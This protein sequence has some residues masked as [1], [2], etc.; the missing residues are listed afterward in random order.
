[1]YRGS[2]NASLLM[3]LG[4]RLLNLKQRLLFRGF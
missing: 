4:L 3:L 1:V 2:T